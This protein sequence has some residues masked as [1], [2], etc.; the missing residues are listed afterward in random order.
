MSLG[1][2][3]MGGDCKVVLPEGRLLAKPD[4]DA[5]LPESLVAERGKQ[6]DEVGATNRRELWHEPQLGQTQLRCGR[7]RLSHRSGR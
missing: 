2:L 4:V 1:N 5:A 3:T 7:G 6:L